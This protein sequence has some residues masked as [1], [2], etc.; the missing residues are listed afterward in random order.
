MDLLEE[1]D[2][3]KID[4][5]KQ[6]KEEI[7]VEPIDLSDKKGTVQLSKD[8]QGLTSKFLKLI[9]SFEGQSQTQLKIRRMFEQFVDLCYKVLDPRVTN[10]LT[11]KYNKQIMVSKLNDKSR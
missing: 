9:I 8:L 10:A 1:I 3:L 11:Y 2:H 6:P 4:W 5:K 7:N